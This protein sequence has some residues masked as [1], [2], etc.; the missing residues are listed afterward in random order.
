[1]L[2]VNIILRICKYF[3][4]YL[5][6]CHLLNLFSENRSKILLVYERYLLS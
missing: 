4:C 5:S 3:E 1:M 6:E 2:S